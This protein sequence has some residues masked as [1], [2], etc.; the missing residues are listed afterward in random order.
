MT[1]DGFYAVLL[2]QDAFDPVAYY[3]G[4]NGMEIFP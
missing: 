2:D 4:W 1:T 3:M